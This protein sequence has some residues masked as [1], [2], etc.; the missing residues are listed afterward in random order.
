MKKES[1]LVVEDEDIMRESLVD[2]FK[3][4]GSLSLISFAQDLSAQ[5]QAIL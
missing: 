2:W 4:S 3:T 5:R 1:I